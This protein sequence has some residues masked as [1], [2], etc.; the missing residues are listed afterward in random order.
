[1]L[2]TLLVTASILSSPIKLLCPESLTNTIRVEGILN[3]WDAISAIDLD[4]ND[5]VKGADKIKGKTDLKAAI[6]CSYIKGEGIYF[7]I[8]ITD[9]RI[10]RN[11]K[12]PKKNDDHFVF[13]L[14]HKR[15]KLSVYPPYRSYKG[16]VK[17]LPKNA[18]AKVVTTEFG[19]ALEL[20][21]PWGM[22][23]TVTGVPTMPINI[24]VYDTD[25]AVVGKPETILAL[26][27]AK[28]PKMTNLEF[29]GARQLFN[30]VLEKLGV[31][32]NDVKSQTVGNFVRGKG[33][34]RAILVDKYLAVI[35]GDIGA[36]FF[37][38][39]LANDAKD[40]LGFKVLD[41]DG[42][43]LLDF[44]VEYQYGNSKATWKVI[45]TYRLVPR[46]V[47]KIFTHLLE[48]KSG[49]HFIINSYKL[50]K[51]KKKY[52]IKFK[53]VKA[54]K[55]ITKKLWKGNSTDPKIINLLLP[56]GAKKETFYFS[57]GSYSGGR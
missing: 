36:N 22:F 25:S 31:S 4:K 10:I 53:F 2:Y 13:A 38:T 26:D 6:R 21:V 43:K 57:N 55:T 34:E 30:S 46:G 56:W 33:L 37:Y 44:A 27:K 39:P 42:D 19:Y 16:V 7:L 8:E 24:T 32:A 9:S 11:K 40:V 50:S 18:K 3:E 49:K 20:G 14:N 23:K 15:Y 28:F 45:S 29:G 17:G 5:A 54:S 1:M 41:L 48:F 52:R 35:G 51:K 12:R 47:R